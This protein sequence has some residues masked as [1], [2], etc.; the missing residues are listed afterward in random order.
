[1]QILKNINMFV[2][3]NKTIFFSL[4]IVFLF[5]LIYIFV[6]KVKLLEDKH[7]KLI[8]KKTLTILKYW[9]LFL[10]M[11]FLSL[12]FLHI[13]IFKKPILI[14]NNWI[15][16]VSVLDVSKSMNAIDFDYDWY[17]ISRLQAGKTLLNNFIDNHKYDRFW[18]VIFSKEATSICPLTIDHEIFLNILDSVDYSNFTKQWTNISKAINLWISRFDISENRSKVLLLITDWWDEEIKNIEWIKKEL[19]E[20]NIKLYILWIWTEKWAKIPLWKDVWWNIIFQTYNWRNVIVKINLDSLNKLSKKLWW[21][22]LKIKKVKDIS[23]IEKTLSSL[24]KNIL[25]SEKWEEYEN[26]SR[27]F[28]FL[29]MVFFIFYI[30]SWIIWKQKQWKK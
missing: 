2:N 1:M 3:D 16:I 7:S 18:L 28:S 30:L 25:K 6:K 21:E 17:K 23:K 29:S 19:K 26:M 8:K 12:W 22:F 15:D 9:F 27:F 24:E 4:V 10:S 5:Y 20:K 14:K 13:K 11:F